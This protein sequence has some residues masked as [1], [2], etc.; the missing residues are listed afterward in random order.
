MKNE[1]IA[2]GED[3]IFAMVSTIVEKE[4]ADCAVL[5]KEILKFKIMKSKIVQYYVRNKQTVYE[6][7][8]IDVLIQL[9]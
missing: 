5:E 7:D 6:S 3:E 1:L 2:Y 8:I 9:I 4:C